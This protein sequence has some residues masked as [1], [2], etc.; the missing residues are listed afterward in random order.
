MAAEEFINQLKDM[1]Y[2]V[3]ELGDGCIAFLYSIPVG[4]RAGEE[5]K[6]G[7]KVQPDFPINPPATGPHITPEFYP[8]ES[9][10]THPTGG[11]HLPQYPA[12]G[13]GWQ[14]WSRPFPD[15]PSS[16]RNARSYMSFINRLFEEV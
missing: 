7:F 12:F 3:E 10:G 14:Y 4:S 5:V 11:I 6:I 15:W 1:D 8:Y 16:A 13:A 2:T 9:G